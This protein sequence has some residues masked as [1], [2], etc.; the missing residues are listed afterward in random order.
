MWRLWGFGTRT[1]C[2]DQLN[3]LA[4]N[5][6]LWIESVVTCH[7]PISC[8]SAQQSAPRV[9]DCL[10]GWAAAFGRWTLSPPATRARTPHKTAS[11]QLLA[12]ALAV[13]DPCSHVH[14]YYAYLT[15][16]LPPPP[17]LSDSTLPA[18]HCRLISSWQ[19]TKFYSQY[20]FLW[21]RGGYFA[22][23]RDVFPWDQL[24]VVCFFGNFQ[25]VLPLECGILNLPTVLLPVLSP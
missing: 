19:I 5:N 8:H 22:A 23:F 25:V 9:L 4:C 7:P 13:V 15:L 3:V 18:R 2:T 12:S 24:K 21:H 14:I 16:T 20:L 10:C 11:G 6:T 17:Q 1:T